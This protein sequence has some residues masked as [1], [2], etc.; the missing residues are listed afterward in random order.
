MYGTDYRSDRTYL[1]SW[2]DSYVE[3]CTGRGFRLLATY[4]CQ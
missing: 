3:G 2:T 4:S 1:Y